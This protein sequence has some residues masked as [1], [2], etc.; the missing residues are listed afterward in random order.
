M[1]GVDH[2]RADDGR[3]LNILECCAQHG[4]VV[5]ME[6]FDLS[7]GKLAGILDRTVKASDKEG[8]KCRRKGNRD[9]G[10]PVRWWQADTV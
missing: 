5:I 3:I 8:C 10:M 7:R 2:A 1:A 9:G 6:R 4:R